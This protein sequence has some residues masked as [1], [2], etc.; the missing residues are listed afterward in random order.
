MFAVLLVF[1]SACLVCLSIQL[2]ELQS[3]WCAERKK[4][5]LSMYVTHVRHGVYIDGTHGDY[6]IYGITRFPRLN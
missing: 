2:G 1:F 3:V 4:S 5:I 6:T